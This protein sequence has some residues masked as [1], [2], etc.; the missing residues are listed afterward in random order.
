LARESWVGCSSARIKVEAPKEI[1]P[2]L[3]TRGTA[4]SCDELWT[5]CHQ[6]RPP[7]YVPARARY[8][9]KIATDTQSRVVR[10]GA[11]SGT[12]V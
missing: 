11:M 10:R 7:G 6:W 4:S 5:Q 2:A 3:K 8:S 12:A 1:S 9:A